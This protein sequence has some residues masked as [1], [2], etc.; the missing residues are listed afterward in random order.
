MVISNHSVV[1]LISSK[2]L[3]TVKPKYT[4]KTNRDKK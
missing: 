4:N 2:P 3:R 1:D